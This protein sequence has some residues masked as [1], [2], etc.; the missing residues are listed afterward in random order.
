MLRR[1]ELPLN[2]SNILQGGSDI[3]SFSSR[4]WTFTTCA[5][6]KLKAHCEMELYQGHRE[7]ETECIK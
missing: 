2:F 7:F 5:S 1:T 4:Q 3:H 6:G